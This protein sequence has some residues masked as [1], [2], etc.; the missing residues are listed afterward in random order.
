MRERFPDE[1]AFDLAMMRTTA[2]APAPVLL[3]TT[4]RG[5]ERVPFAKA[6]NPV[7]QAWRVAEFGAI[8]ASTSTTTWSTVPDLD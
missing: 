6:P 2:F 8:P 7:R 4:P 1:C 3:V 5:T